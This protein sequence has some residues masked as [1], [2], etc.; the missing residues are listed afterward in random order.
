MD[1][2]K[3][4]EFTPASLDDVIDGTAPQPEALE[5]TATPDAEPAPEPQPAPAQAATEPE[6]T[7]PAPESWTYAMA[8]DE[9]SKRQALQ[10]ELETERQQRAAM[11]WQA[12]Q[13]QKPVEAP[14]I[15]MDQAAY[16]DYILQKAQGAIDPRIQALEARLHQQAFQMAKSQHGE[17]LDAA[18]QWFNTLDQSQQT[19]LNER[20]GQQPD[21]YAGLMSEFSRAEIAKELS[22]PSEFE[23]F[24]AWKASQAGLTA[25]PQAQAQPVP[26]APRPSQV[27]L[28]PS[29]M[30]APS[31]AP[32]SG[33]VWTGPPSLGDILPE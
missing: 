30:S 15:L 20:Y 6:P 17:G 33:P 10:K 3:D 18:L 2:L 24:K 1:T 14:D 31:M 11:E 28:T 27:K 23:A 21:P 19:S 16:D 25:Q 8:M 26:T 22:D 13:A 5:V 29:V 4:E 32:R 7:E 12:K 9:K